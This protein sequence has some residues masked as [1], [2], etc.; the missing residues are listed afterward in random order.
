MLRGRCDSFVTKTH[1]EYPTDIGLLFDAIRKIIIYTARL[2][3]DYGLSEWRQYQFNIKQIKRS[4]R[5][6]QLKKR[7]QRST[8][9]RLKQQRIGAAHRHYLHLVERQLQRA[10]TT[11]QQLNMQHTLNTSQLVTYT[12]IEQYMQHADRQ[13]DQIRR[14]V[15]NG[16]VIPH[17][18]KVFSVFQ[19]HTEW[20]VKGKAGVPMELG[21]RVG[22][23]EDQYQFILHHKVMERQTDDQ[24]AVPL[25]EE[26]QQ[27]F[28]D[29]KTWRC[30]QG[31]PSPSKQVAL[32]TW[33]APV[34]LASNGK[35]AKRVRAREQSTEFQQAHSQH[36]AVESA[37]NALQVH[38]LDCCPDH[39]IEGFKRYVCLAILARN[40]QRLGEV[41]IHR[42]RKR[43]ARMER[44]RAA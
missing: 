38:G 11:L 33:L 44:R 5:Q 10:R 41:L 34:A 37:I 28:A 31:F 19:P 16:E 4:L 8:D 40:I 36:A 18:E 14:R 2:H 39:G 17:T 12:R 15:L 24:V 20:I 32:A 23:V 3:E 35:P 42:H 1:V 25:I 30:A 6:T 43:Q 22:I 21:I 27:R 26:T 13:M 29:L 9:D 7:H